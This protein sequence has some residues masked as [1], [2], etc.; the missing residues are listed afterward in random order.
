MH[1][2]NSF[3]PRVNPSV[4]ALN[5]LRPVGKARRVVRITRLADRHPHIPLHRPLLS[6]IDQG[7]L[8]KVAG[9]GRKLGV[10]E[11]F[12]TV[13]WDET[14]FHQGRLV[15]LLDELE[16]MDTEEGVVR[17]AT[18]AKNIGALIMVICC[19]LPS[20]NLNSRPIPRGP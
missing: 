20:A 8:K 13:L 16:G 19:L 3:T 10:G 17:V 14:P 1:W 15:V 7:F 6:A 18:M 9:H 5:S 2:Q 11:F 12:L 4:P